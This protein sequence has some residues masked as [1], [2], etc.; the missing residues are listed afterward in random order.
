M[1]E[2]EPE[3]SKADERQPAHDRADGEH[4]AGPNR[5]AAESDEP[6]PPRPTQQ[7]V[8]SDQEDA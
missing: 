3:E 4:A 2:L 5:E 6:G 7:I 1:S 8:V